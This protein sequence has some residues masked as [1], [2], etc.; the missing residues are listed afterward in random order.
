LAIHPDQEISG[1]AVRQPLG[2]QL[3][4]RGAFFD[5]DS[6]GESGPIIID[7]GNL[8]GGSVEG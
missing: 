3:L 1:A 8:H 2:E 6:I 4:N 5:L 7:V